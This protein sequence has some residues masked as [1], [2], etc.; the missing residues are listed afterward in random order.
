MDL[1]TLEG[2]LEADAPSADSNAVSLTYFETAKQAALSGDESVYGVVPTYVQGVDES[3]QPV[4][5]VT[6]THNLN[7]DG[8]LSSSTMQMTLEPGGDLHIEKSFMDSSQHQEDVASGAASADGPVVLRGEVHIAVDRADGSVESVSPLKVTEHQYGSP[9]DNVFIK[10]H[11]ERAVDDSYT[12]D[13]DATMKDVVSADGNM[14]DVKFTGHQ[15]YDSAGELAAESYSMVQTERMYED[16]EMVEKTQEFEL[17]REEFE[18]M[19]TQAFAME[20]EQ[21]AAQTSGLDQD[22][23]EKDGSDLER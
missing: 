3:G 6:V 12:V 9:E 19:R 10:A 8:W 16:G 11:V 13:F 5:Q 7:E 1:N 23:A 18:E 22:A 14:A 20:R 17:T 4:E 2:V 21:R 15:T